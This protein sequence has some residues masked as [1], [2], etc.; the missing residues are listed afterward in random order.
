MPAPSE[1]VQLKLN[2]G[3][4][5]GD[6]TPSEVKKG[7]PT[8]KHGDVVSMGTFILLPCLS[9]RFWIFLLYLTQR[10]RNQK[11]KSLW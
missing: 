11:T 3:A 10:S 5:D 4:S 8:G 2:I 7:T 6:S 1:L 9:S